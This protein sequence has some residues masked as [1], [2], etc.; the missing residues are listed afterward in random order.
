VNKN[1]SKEEKKM[2][3]ANM[4]NILHIDSWGNVNKTTVRYCWSQQWDLA[5]VSWHLAL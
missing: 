5:F 4:K 2:I 1:F 3:N